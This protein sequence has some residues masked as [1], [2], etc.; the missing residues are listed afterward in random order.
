MADTRQTAE[1]ALD[2][3]IEFYGTKHEKAVEC[4]TKD[5]E[6]LFAFCDP[7]PS[8]GSIYARRMRSTSLFC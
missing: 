1:A 7:P 4:P 8:I 5:R 6:G 3:F 2:T